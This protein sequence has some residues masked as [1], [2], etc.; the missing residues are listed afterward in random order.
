MMINKPLKNVNGGGLPAKIFSQIMTQI[1]FELSSKKE[2][3]MISPGQFDALR[4]YDETL[5]KYQV[6]SQEVDER[7][8]DSSLIGGLIRALLWGN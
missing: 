5:E 2:I 4:T 3:G 1:S 8:K 6:Q 7:S